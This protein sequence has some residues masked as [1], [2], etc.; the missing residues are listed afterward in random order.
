MFHHARYNALGYASCITCVVTYIGWL[1][2]SVW[3]SLRRLG[4]GY[5]T[6]KQGRVGKERDLREGRS[7]GRV[8]THEVKRWCWWWWWWWL[9]WHHIVL[10]LMLNTPLYTY[11]YTNTYLY[12]LSK[13][14][15]STCSPHQPLSWSFT[16][17]DSWA[18]EKSPP[19]PKINQ[20]YFVFWLKLI[21]QMIWG[22][23]SRFHAFI[24]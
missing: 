8:T 23:E 16:V 12:I 15:E 4:V 2:E 21:D 9:P 11:A 22:G 24:S 14:Q 1:W 18:S 6:S 10:V 3:R 5:P 13:S 20:W 7:I 19:P 17:A